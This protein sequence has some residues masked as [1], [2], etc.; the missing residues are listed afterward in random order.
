MAWTKLAYGTIAAAAMLT[1]GA[2]VYYN[3]ADRPASSVATVEQIATLMEGTLEHTAAVSTWP[4]TT[5]S[6]NTA[7]WWNTTN[8][9]NAVDWNFNFYST[10]PLLAMTAPRQAMQETLTQITNLIPQYVDRV[11]GT[12]IVYFTVTGLWD[13]LDI[14]DGVNKFTVGV[15]NGG[16]VYDFNV[17]STLSTV[18]LEEA[19][20]LLNA[21][22]TTVRFCATTHT[23]SEAVGYGYYSTNEWTYTNEF[24][25]RFNTNSDPA[26]L[27]GGVPPDGPDSIDAIWQYNYFNLS[28][29]TNT[30]M[31]NWYLGN[32]PLP[33]QQILGIPFN[34]ATYERMKEKVFDDLTQWV[35]NDITDDLTIEYGWLVSPPYKYYVWDG[36][37]DFGMAVAEFPTGVVADVRL[38]WQIDATW[39][40]T[41]RNADHSF[42][43]T[44]YLESSIVTGLSTT[45]T[46]TNVVTTNVWTNF[47]V[48][49][50]PQVTNHVPTNLH[51]VYGTYYL[52]NATTNDSGVV[53]E[54]FYWRQS[55]TN[56][57]ITNFTFGATGYDGSDT[58]GG[59]VTVA[60]EP[61][62]I[63]NWTFKYR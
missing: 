7:G 9:T 51:A 29:L 48:W 40:V 25:G 54:T 14:G 35:S 55:A 21:M 39:A 30:V 44:N 6:G 4:F 27:A 61:V 37:N 45:L 59:Y 10:I 33:F 63:F 41:G 1:G 32:F 11:D 5:N 57:T 16:V 24:L 17:G 22:T 46:F 18:T 62:A 58:H 52:S 20:A 15:T 47:S 23:Q 2:I 38:V 13:R 50:A 31:T 19:W 12:N 8:L 56:T 42:I 28:E 60:D 36:S 49:I 53:R 26:Y 3:H 34:W 43:S